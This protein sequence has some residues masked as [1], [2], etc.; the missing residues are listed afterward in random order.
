[1]NGRV[2]QTNC[3]IRHGRMA[4]CYRL[5]FPRDPPSSPRQPRTILFSPFG[6]SSLLFDR[7]NSTS[8]DLRV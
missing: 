8:D 3:K 7:E 6:L 1:M 4:A 2:W 5:L